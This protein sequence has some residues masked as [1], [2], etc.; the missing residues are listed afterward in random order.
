MA[1]SI[2]QAGKVKECLLCRMEAEDIGYYGELLHT[3]LH[4]H[5]FIH[6]TANRKKAEHYGLWAYVCVKRHHEYGPEAPHANAEVD[7]K[8]KRMAQRKFEER[9]SRE[10]WMQEFKKN[11][12]DDDKEEKDTDRESA[13]KG[14]TFIEDPLDG[15]WDE[16]EGKG[17]V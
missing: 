4:K 7:R 16:Q 14:I 11:Y 2:I 13:E 6:G 3:G 8:L 10:L 1:K 5:H 15:P 9:Y 12:L 17:Y